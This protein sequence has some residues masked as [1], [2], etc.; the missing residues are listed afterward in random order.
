MERKS[1]SRPLEQI[2]GPGLN[3]GHERLKKNENGNSWCSV[4]SSQW[5]CNE[6]VFGGR[7]ETSLDT[8]KH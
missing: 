1:L 8:R 7:N 2:R 6:A 4:S 5:E 3:W